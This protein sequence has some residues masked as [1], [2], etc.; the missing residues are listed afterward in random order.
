MRIPCPYCGERDSREFSYLG[1]EPG[2]RPDGMDADAGAMFEHVYQRA[3]PAGPV[4]EY[5]Y[6]TAGCHTWLV[7]ERDTRTH[8]I[9]GVTPAANRQREVQS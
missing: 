8:A 6:H 3:N 1:G 9:S 7:V 5:W 4:R 2:P